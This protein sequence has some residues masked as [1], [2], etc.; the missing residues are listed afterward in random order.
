MVS[1]ALIRHGEMLARKAIMSVQLQLSPSVTVTR[2]DFPQELTAKVR[3]LLDSRNCPEDVRRLAGDVLD[4]TALL[5]TWP[6][7]R[8]LKLDE[9]LR[10]QISGLCRFSGGSLCGVQQCLAHQGA[11]SNRPCRIDRTTN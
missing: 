8:S 4:L 11:G 6:V 7:P 5:A 3:R 2:I 10:R 9:E 1:H